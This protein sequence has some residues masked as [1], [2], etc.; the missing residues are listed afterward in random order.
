MPPRLRRTI[1]TGTTATARPKAISALPSFRRWRHLLRR[2][3]ISRDRKH[4]QPWWPATKLRAVRGVKQARSGW[5]QPHQAG[6]GTFGSSMKPSPPLNYIRS[7][8][9]SARHLSLTAAA[10]ELGYTQAAVSSH[11]RGLERYI[12]RQL[13]IRYPR[14]LKLTEMGEA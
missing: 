5:S 8:E 14:S 3:A 6:P 12:G 7:F 10:K 1:W 2:A 13:F 4:W 11:V 9:C